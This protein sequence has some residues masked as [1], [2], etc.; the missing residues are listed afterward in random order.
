[1]S[2]KPADSGTDGQLQARVNGVDIAALREEIRAVRSQLSSRLFRFGVRNRW[3]H[4]GHTRTTANDA[5]AAGSLRTSRRR[6]V[7]L[8]SDLSGLLRGSDRAMTPLEHLLGALASCLTTTLVWSASVR[9]LH[10]DAVETRIEGDI[11]ALVSVGNDAG[12]RPGFRRIS[13]SVTLESDAPDIVLQELLEV[14]KRVS[15]VLN[16]IVGGASVTLTR[17]PA[18]AV[19]DPLQVKND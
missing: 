12:E 17:A 18:G 19:G 7:V 5:R 2:N 10:L 1:M 15:P 9:G 6:P 4:G 11:D 8:E 14:A 3:L 13:M 16:T